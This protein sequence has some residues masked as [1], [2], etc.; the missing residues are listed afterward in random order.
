MWKL[1]GLKEKTGNKLLLKKWVEPTPGC[2]MPN[3]IR[4]KVNGRRFIVTKTSPKRH[5][6]IVARNLNCT[7][8]NYLASII[9]KTIFYI[10]LIWETKSSPQWIG[11][12]LSLVGE[13]SALSA[14]R[15]IHFYWLSQSN[16]VSGKFFSFLTS[17]LFLYSSSYHWNE[18][19]S[20]GKK[21]FHCN[22]AIFITW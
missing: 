3:N 20:P 14:F 10:L 7:M 15:Q 19:S 2:R 13:Y 22:S 5:W 1:E 17:F 9:A 8:Q 18:F 12:F 16:F 4:L 6:L 21:E 11:V